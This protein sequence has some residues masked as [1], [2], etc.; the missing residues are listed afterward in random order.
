[1]GAFTKTRLRALAFTA[2]IALVWLNQ[3]IGGKDWEALRDRTF[4]DPQAHLTELVRWPFLFLYRRSGDEAIYFATASATLGLPYDTE[5]FAQRGDSPLPPVTTPVDGRFHL[6]YAEIPFEY[7]PPNVP[8]VLAPRL[9]TSRFTTYAYVFGALMGVLLVAAAAIG[10]RIGARPGGDPRD[11]EAHRIFAFGLL[12]LA[13]GSIAVQRLDAIVALLAVLMVR[14]AA[15]D[16]DRGLGLWAGLIGAAKFVPVLLLPAIVLASGIR[17]RRRLLTISLFAALGLGLG[18]GPMVVLGRAS[19]PLILTYHAARGLHVE[20]SLGVVYGAVKAV[21][22]M[23]EASTMDYGSFNFHGPVSQLLAKASTFVTL[24]LVAVVLR[25][26]TRKREAAPESDE[27]REQRTWRIVLAALATMSA[28]W[29]GG[30]V[31]SP[32]YLTWALPLVIAVPGRGWRRIAVSFG[33]ILVI[34]QVYLRGFYDHVYNQWP[35]GVITMVI[36]LAVLIAF[37]LVFVRALRAERAQ[38]VVDA[39]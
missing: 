1:M 18:L 29:L 24:G 2:F 32:Q 36:R 16:D 8:F 28:L 9:V 20:S 10:A 38:P 19:L 25:A 12:L 33:V 5:V 39:Q 37:F 7:P 15:R 31:F 11:S 21:L 30:K 35:A 17:D 6:P 26:S 34:S 13:H 22:G 3:S 14:S 27:A 4:A 23:R